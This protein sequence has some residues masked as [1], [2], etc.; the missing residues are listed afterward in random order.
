MIVARTGRTSS[1]A[2]LRNSGILG[3]RQG[4][5]H[6]RSRGRS[7]DSGRGPS[8][9]V[10]QSAT[11]SSCSMMTWPTSGSVP[12]GYDD[13]VGGHPAVADADCDGAGYRPVA[14]ASV[15]VGAGAGDAAHHRYAEPLHDVGQ[16]E[17]HGAGIRNR[18][19]GDA[20]DVSLGQVAGLRQLTVPDV[21]QA[22]VRDDF[23]LGRLLCLTLSHR[24]DQRYGRGGGS[25]AAWRRGGR[26]GCQETCLGRRK[27]ANKWLVFSHLHCRQSCQNRVANRV[28]HATCVTDPVG[29]PGVGQPATRRECGPT[30]PP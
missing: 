22:D 8:V 23:A 15:G 28:V 18:L 11:R 2:T 27:E 3:S 25:T 4:R 30:E 24:L 6:S 13:A 21:L 17:H 19:H 29:M 12:V 16:R 26:A 20:A 14:A 7:G 5:R 1:W 9:C 10:T